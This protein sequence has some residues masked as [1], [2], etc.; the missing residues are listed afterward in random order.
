MH[1]ERLVNSLARKKIV[2][3][4]VEGPSDEDALGVLL[5]KVFDKNLVYV[6]VTHCDVTTEWGVSS[7]N[8]L[9]K[10]G[11]IVKGYADST[12]LKKVHFQRVI[13]ILDTDGAYVPDKA[14]AE[15]GNAE[16]NIYSLTKIQTKNVNGILERNKRK[17]A[18][19]DRLS[20]ANAVWGDVPYQ[21][22]YM[23]CN[24]DHVLYDK[25]NL[26]DE[27]KEKN[28]LAFAKRYRENIDGFIRYISD[29]SF[30]VP[31]EYRET[32][33]FIKQDLHSLER[34]T[35]LGLS[36]VDAKEKE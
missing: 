14:V 15:D 31:G 17:S 7:D 2:F 20:I 23:S 30:S 1:L 32:W 18:C 21:A 13:H 34:H 25:L 36:L 29:S 27:E 6:H 8:V 28:S 12:H 35:N 9:S 26:S 11:S 10:I 24:L 5:G 16:K 19:L 4:I 3:V 22:Y 33:N